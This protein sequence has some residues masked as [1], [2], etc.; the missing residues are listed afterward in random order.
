MSHTFSWQEFIIIRYIILFLKIQKEK[1][2]LLKVKIYISEDATYVLHFSG[3]SAKQEMLRE[4]NSKHKKC[5]Q[6]KFYS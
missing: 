2:N 3:S 4:N 1:K 6:T 5:L